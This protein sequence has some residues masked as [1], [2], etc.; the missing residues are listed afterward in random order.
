MPVQLPDALLRAVRARKCILFVGSGLSSAAGYP[1]WGELVERLVDEAKRMPYARMEGLEEIEEQKDFFTLAEFARATL[2]PTQFA[3][4]LKE[5]LGRPVAPSQAHELIARTD[6][7]GVVTTN[8]DRLLETTVTKT[9]SWAPST[10]TSNML[11]QLGVALFNAEFF[12]YKMHGDVASPAS[13]VLSASDYDRMILRSP[14]ARS[15]LQ[16]ALLNYTLLFVGY[17]LRDPDF[18]LVLRELSLIFENYVPRH[19]ALLANAGDFAAEHLMRRLNIQAIPYDP[20]GGHR[21]VAD[22]LETLRE[23]APFHEP[24]FAAAV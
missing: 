18:H 10:F 13:I 11:E 17:S 14:H 19:F 24:R 22:V 3:D 9:R 20:A 8:Y 23:L 6:F 4:V 7:R 15:F 1:T 2:S 16:A 5:A 21:E 12:V